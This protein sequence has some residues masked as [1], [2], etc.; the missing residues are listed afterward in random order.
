[1]SATQVPLR[2]LPKGTLAKFWLGFLL[3]V[4]AA[5]GL[6]WYGAGSLRGEVTASGTRIVT[7]KDGSGD[8]VKAVDGIMVEYEGRLPD[9]TVF[10]STAGRGPA[11][12]IPPTP[13]SSQR[14]MPRTSPPFVKWQAGTARCRA[15]WAWRWTWARRC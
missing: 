5:L 8:P 9:G 7:L 12:M 2:P 4:G 13:C 1:M 3:L 11:P 15:S 10:D 14:S 6:A